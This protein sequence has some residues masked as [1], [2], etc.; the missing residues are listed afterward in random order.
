MGLL[1]SFS[2]ASQSLRALQMAIQTTGH[3]VANAATPGFSRQRVE[4]QTEF[5]SFEG[6]VYLGQGVNV[7]GVRSVLDHFVEAE[8]LTINGSVGYAEAEQRALAGVSDAFPTTGGLDAAMNAFFGA[9][10]DLSNNPSGLP[11]RISLIG[12]ARALG[13][14]FARTREVLTSLQGNLDQDIESFARRVN[15][16]TSQIATLNHQINSTESASQ[17]AN[18]FRDQRQILLQ[19]IV[20][21]TGASVR[22]QQDGQVTVIAD[23]LLLVSADRFASFDTSQVD[24]LTGFHM[25]LYK[26]QEG[27]S[28][29]ATSILKAGQIGATLKMRDVEIQGYIDRLDQ[30][31]KTLV[32]EVNLQHGLGFDLTGAAG[33]NFFSPIAAVTGAASAIQVDNAVAAD[34]RLIAAAGSAAGFPG[35]NVNA[36][37]LVNLQS[38][39]FAALGGLTLNDSFTVLAADVGARAQDTEGNFNFKK[40]LLVQ[41]QARRESV[42]GVNIDEEMTNLLLFQRTFEASSRMVRVTD[43]MYQTLIDMVR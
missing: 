34:S 9:L 37:A 15:V 6:G 40:D 1:S 27:L 7:S 14:N 13:E 43:E 10:S 35:D 4:V 2:L 11:E 36:L 22:E 42:S 30:L 33:G 32:D 31:A 26:T 24:P 19:E 28:F 5:P 29:D 17:P 39:A 12:K 16:L 8:L 41:A 20:N 38:T 3:N 25:L 18:D 21:L 23:G